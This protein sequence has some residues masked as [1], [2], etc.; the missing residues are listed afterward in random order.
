[1]QSGAM[2]AWMAA[3]AT[4]IAELSRWAEEW[5]LAKVGKDAAMERIF[6]RMLNETCKRL[7]AVVVQ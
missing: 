5:A 7:E 3:H 1:V 6:G 2:S 4:E